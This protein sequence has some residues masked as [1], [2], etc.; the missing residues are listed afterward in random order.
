[1]S[2]AELRAELKELRKASDSHRPI[3]RMKKAD[4]TAQ[5]EALK[6]ARETT[7][8]AAAVPSVKTKAAP[9]SAKKHIM[10]A[11]E[12]EF[13]HSKAP[14]RAEVHAHRESHLVGKKA[15]EPKKKLSK[16]MLRA[17]LDEMS[18]SDE[19]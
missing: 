5:L 7:A 14:H 10:A 8:H 15:A 17:M 12:T 3:S 1:M 9:E 2:L 19:E 11:K 18:S 13:P 16:S 6:H 4:I